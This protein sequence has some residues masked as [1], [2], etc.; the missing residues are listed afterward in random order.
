MKA[1][2]PYVKKTISL[3]L[4][5]RGKSNTLWKLNS[6]HPITWSNVCT[7]EFTNKKKTKLYSYKRSD[8][9]GDSVYKLIKAARR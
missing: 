6:K 7:A 3:E 5:Q 1:G 4:P 9:Q 8:H 2:V